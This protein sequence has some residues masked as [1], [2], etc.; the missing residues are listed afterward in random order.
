[1]SSCPD[2][3]KNVCFDYLFVYF[4]FGFSARPRGPSLNLFEN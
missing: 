4:D 1:M 2:Y 3:L